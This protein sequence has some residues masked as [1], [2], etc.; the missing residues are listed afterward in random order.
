M[1]YIIL[2]MMVKQRKILNGTE[3]KH[4]YLYRCTVYF[5]VQVTHQ[6]MHI[7]SL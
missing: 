3:N 6:Q 4:E 5:V 1:A 7:Y 2:P